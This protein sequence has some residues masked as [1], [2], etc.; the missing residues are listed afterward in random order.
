MAECGNQH[1]ERRGHQRAGNR[2]DRETGNAALNAD[3]EDD[4][5]EYEADTQD[6][7]R[8]H[9]AADHLANQERQPGDWRAAQPLPESALALQQHLDAEV[10]HCEQQKLNAHTGERVR[11]A[12][13]E[14]AGPSGHCLLFDHVGQRQ[15][16]HTRIA[17]LT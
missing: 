16:R 5:R 7:Q 17:R 9:R 11:V 12:V 8:N 2:D 3:T 13:V 1:A 14:C 15:S 6:Q 4:H 10:R